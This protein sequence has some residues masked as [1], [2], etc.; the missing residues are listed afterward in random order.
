M[1]VKNPSRI[2]PSSGYSKS[3]ISG[4]GGISTYDTYDQTQIIFSTVS[5]LFVCHE[6][7]SSRNKQDYFVNM[8]HPNETTYK[9]RSPQAFIAVFIILS[10]ALGYYIMSY[11]WENKD[12]AEKYTTVTWKLKKSTR[13]LEK[14]D[15]KLKTCW[16][17][18][19]S[20]EQ[21]NS[22]LQSKVAKLE[23]EQTST[24]SEK[25]EVGKKY[26]DAV[27]FFQSVKSIV[28]NA[29][30]QLSK[31]EKSDPTSEMYSALKELLHQWKSDRVLYSNLKLSNQ[32][33]SGI[34]SETKSK[35]V[36]LEIDNG[37]LTDQV[38]QLEE[39]VST[40]TEEKT[41]T[42]TSMATLRE[43][44]EAAKKET[45]VRGFRQRQSNVHVEEPTS[46]QH[47]RRVEEAIQHRAFPTHGRRA[48]RKKSK[49]DENKKEEE[50]KKKEEEKNSEK[51]EEEEEEDKDMKGDEAKK[52]ERTIT[53]SP[54]VETPAVS[55]TPHNET[56]DAESKTTSTVESYDAQEEALKPHKNT[57][58]L[59]HSTKASNANSTGK[60]NDTDVDFD[61]TE[62]GNS[63]EENSKGQEKNDDE[64]ARHGKLDRD[65]EEKVEEGDDNEGDDNENDFT[66]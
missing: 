58:E 16:S 6:D 57:S 25:T 63:K 34:L 59:H 20:M 50:E 32:E 13:T 21:S 5:C 10:V 48:H 35:N 62:E 41:Q 8:G 42:E 11:S 29:D 44:L 27:D 3:Q 51:E 39:K 60:E 1:H 54:R 26:A 31:D 33:Q 38:K 56:N 43:E 64:P 40:L 45:N 53:P 52:E 23:E 28:G 18:K 4:N 49:V 65:E 36:Q 30:G 47:E 55:T 22:E 12:L 24:M 14:T 17:E 15:M 37:K 66:T 9:M 7:I 2:I 19:R 46:S 61:E